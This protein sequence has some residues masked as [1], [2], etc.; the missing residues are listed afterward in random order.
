MNLLATL[1]KAY[2]GDFFGKWLRHGL[3][4]AQLD[5]STHVKLNVPETP[6][7]RVE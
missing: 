4:A 7:R 6:A 2:A 5:N 1:S 3:G